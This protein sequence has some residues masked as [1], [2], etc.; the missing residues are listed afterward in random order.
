M[1]ALE[2]SELENGWV[3]DMDAPQNYL[4]DF[5]KAGHPFENNLPS[6]SHGGGR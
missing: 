4:P 2:E 6:P 5:E 1:Q 3:Q